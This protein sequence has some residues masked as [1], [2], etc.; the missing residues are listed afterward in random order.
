MKMITVVDEMEGAW[1]VHIVMNMTH[2]LMRNFRKNSK[3]EII[4]AEKSNDDVVYWY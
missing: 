2:L 3:I 4:K 1:G